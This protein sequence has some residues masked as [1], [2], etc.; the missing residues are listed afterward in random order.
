MFEIS[1]RCVHPHPL[2]SDVNW[3][4]LGSS[5]GN[6]SEG[7]IMKLRKPLCSLCTF[8]GEHPATNQQP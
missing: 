3:G 7:G 1:V 2:A 6:D 5:T 4:T 8:R